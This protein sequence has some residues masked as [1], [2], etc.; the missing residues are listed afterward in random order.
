[1]QQQYTLSKKEYMY[2]YMCANMHRKISFI[3]LIE[4]CASKS[5]RVLL[6]S[7]IKRVLEIKPIDHL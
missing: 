5:E 4:T 2:I 3:R 1:M 6:L 7:L